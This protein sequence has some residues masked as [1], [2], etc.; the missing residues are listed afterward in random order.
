MQSSNS[1]AASNEELKA[2]VPAPRTLEK[3]ER[4]VAELSQAKF[5]FRLYVAGGTSRSRQAITNIRGICEQ[6]LAD[7]YELEVIDV[8]QQPGVTKSAEL[9]ALPTLIK[10]LPFPRRRFVG[11]MS[12]TERIVLALRLRS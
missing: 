2:D 3:F 7:R 9:V 4:L 12:D 1:K 6:Y 8:Y 11:D 5:L 10:E